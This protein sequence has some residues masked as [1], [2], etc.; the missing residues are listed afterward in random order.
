MWIVLNNLRSTH[1]P[2]KAS[3]SLSSINLIEN[4][5]L[6]SEFSGVSRKEAV[7]SIITLNIILII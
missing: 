1:F 2:L 7:F 6:I 4:I 3:Y 5:I